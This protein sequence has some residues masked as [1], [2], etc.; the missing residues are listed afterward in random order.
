MVNVEA[1]YD[2]ESYTIASTLRN[3]SQSPETVVMVAAFYDE[4]G[5]TACVKVSPLTSVPNDGENTVINMSGEASG[6]NM[7]IFFIK[8]WQSGKIQKNITY[9][10]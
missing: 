3:L 10:Y 4:E 7:K 9:K 2:G 1:V 8:D 6:E 5:N